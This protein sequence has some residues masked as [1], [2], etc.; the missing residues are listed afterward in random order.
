MRQEHELDAT[1]QP[2][3]ALS[4]EAKAACLSSPVVT[5]SLL[6]CLHYCHGSH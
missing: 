3:S 6:I 1:L 5:M 4:R 2:V